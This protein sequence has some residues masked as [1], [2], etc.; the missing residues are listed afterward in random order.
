M[1]KPLTVWITKNW[2][3]LQEMRILDYLTCHLRNQYAGQEA[4]VRSRHGTIDCF[5][6]GKGVWQGCTLS[7]C[8]FNLYAEYIMWCVGLEDSHTG[9]KTTGR[10]INN[11]KYADGTTL[12]AES[13]KKLKEPLDEGERW[14]WKS[15]LKTEHSKK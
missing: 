11:F 2:K 4:I 9:I 8:L 14:E 3:I 1:L 7:L 15:W 13:E 6:I 10:N 12:M 5:K